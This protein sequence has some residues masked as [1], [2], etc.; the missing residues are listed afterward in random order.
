LSFKDF[1][2]FLNFLVLLIIPYLIKV[3]HRLTRLETKFDICIN[4]KRPESDK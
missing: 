2:P 3:E 1:L 4:G